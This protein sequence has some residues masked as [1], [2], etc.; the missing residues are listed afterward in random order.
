MGKGPSVSVAAGRLAI[1]SPESGS[2]SQTL[3]AVP[4]ASGPVGLVFADLA[5]IAAFFA[6]GIGFLA[7]GLLLARTGF[8]FAAADFVAGAFFAAERVI[9]F[10]VMVFS[11]AI[12]TE[13]VQSDGHVNW[14]LPES[15]LARL[16]K[17]ME[18]RQ[19]KSSHLQRVFAS[20]LALKIEN[21]RGLTS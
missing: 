13:A 14:L 4:P 10:M 21:L 15:I 9:F 6:G 19:A 18:R 12:A 8:G 17:T 16:L 3:T 1:L 7:A 2:P 20:Q 5:G 11:K